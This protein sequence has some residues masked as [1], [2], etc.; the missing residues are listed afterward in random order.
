MEGHSA[1]LVRGPGHDARVSGMSG[2]T[3]VSDP[4]GPELTGSL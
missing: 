2:D 4:V 1:P 3:E